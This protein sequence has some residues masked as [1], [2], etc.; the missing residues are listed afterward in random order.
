MRK[1]V[2]DA[3]PTPCLGC[4]GGSCVD[5][6]CLRSKPTACGDPAR[7]IAV[8]VACQESEPERPLMPT[9]HLA[10]DADVDNFVRSAIAEIERRE[11]YEEQLRVALG[12]CRR[13]TQK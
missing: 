1:E 10:G 13:L 11:G 2:A 8:P 9:E 5:A 4:A 3:A 6:V 12:S 7:D